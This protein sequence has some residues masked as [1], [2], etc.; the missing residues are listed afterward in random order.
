MCVAAFAAWHWEVGE[1][2][3]GRIAATR[4]A[5]TDDEVSNGETEMRESTWAATITGM[6]ECRWTQCSVQKAGQYSV[7]GI[8]LAVSSRMTVGRQLW[9]ESGGVEITYRTGAIVLLQGP[10][11]FE[12]DA[13][14]GFLS[15]GRL[16]GI[17]EK[18]TASA[19]DAAFS[20]RPF[21]IS[22]NA[23]TVVDLGTEFGVEV[24]SA[25]RMISHV[26]RGSVAVYPAKPPLGQDDDG[27][28]ILRERE[29]AAVDAA[30]DR[31]GAVNRIP[32][33]PQRF[34]RRL[35]QEPAQ[36]VK[37][38]GTGLSR[39]GWSEDASWQVAAIS[40]IPD[41]Q[42]Q[43]AN[44]IGPAHGWQ[45]NGSGQPQW[46]S[47]HVV[48]PDELP[49]GVICTF[50]TVVELA[51]VDPKN[52]VVN[53]WFLTNG[54]VDAIRL[55]GLDISVPQHDKRACNLFQRFVIDHG[56]V[57]GANSL[58]IDVRKVGRS[59]GIAGYSPYVGICVGLDGIVREQ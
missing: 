3:R 2:G 34:V 49:V 43:P 12:I 32:Y 40:S 6:N 29:S 42:P 45:V 39:R 28:L 47:T 59:P 48:L 54:H 36:R 51:D 1:D 22:T 7:A 20:A 10:A 30:A 27:R 17:F 11:T 26:F 52:A 41:F 58:E 38:C 15:R 9:L 13:N 53:G 46:I 56:F 4:P 33:D 21:T 55:N 44:R 18:N 25:G 19:E 23:G 14:G 50:R 16:T 35:T 57:E 24:D 5:A 37:A 8:D 31:P